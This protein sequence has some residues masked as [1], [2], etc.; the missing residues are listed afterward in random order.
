MQEGLIPRLQKQ[1]EG[2]VT[3]VVDELSPELYRYLYCLLQDAEAT[4]D[5]VQESFL[6]AYAALPRLSHESNIASWLFT[7]ATNVARNHLRRQRIVRWVQLE[8]LSVYQQSHENTVVQQD[9]VGEILA[10][11]PINY[12]MCLI[13]HYWRGL[14]CREIGTIMGMREVA[15]RKLLERARERFRTLYECHQHD[16]KEA[17]DAP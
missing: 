5:C 3:I 17:K 12:R 9:F 14:S 8:W 6:R 1:E 10:Q 7:I 15:V 16:D 13:L 2:A 11:L 4:A